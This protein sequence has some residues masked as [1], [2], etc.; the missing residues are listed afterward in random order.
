M[1]WKKIINQ[2]KIKFIL[3]M[4]KKKIKKTVFIEQ[5]IQNPIGGKSN[6]IYGHILKP[7]L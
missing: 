7:C 3:K 1:K 4:K 2:Q 6:N 5:N